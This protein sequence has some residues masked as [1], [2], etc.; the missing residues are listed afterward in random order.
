M[1]LILCQI[2]LTDLS[3][4]ALRNIRT[5]LTADN[6]MVELFSNF[7]SRYLFYL[8]ASTLHRLTSPLLHRYPEVK[9]MELQFALEHWGEIRASSGLRN[10]I[11]DIA[12]GE[13]PECVEILTTL[14][15]RMLP[16]MQDIECSVISEPW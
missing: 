16:T 10:K 8:H 5:Q 7:T 4:L 15:S 14:L 6:V 2:G 11:A 9:D 12:S 3:A 1:L 13:H